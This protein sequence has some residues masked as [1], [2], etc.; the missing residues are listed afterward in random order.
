MCA[1][2]ST[3]AS[4][5][6]NVRGTVA[7]PHGTGRTVRVLALTQGDKV[8]DAEARVPTLSAVTR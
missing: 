5:I 2:G 1:S 3:R 4:R 6:R 8:R 7:L